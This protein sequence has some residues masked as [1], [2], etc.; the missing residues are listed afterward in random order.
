ML[1]AAIYFAGPRT[2]PSI[3][4]PPAASRNNDAASWPM[5]ALARSYQSAGR[6]REAAE[7]YAKLAALAPN[8][9]QLLADYAFVLGIANGRNLN[10]RPMAL[11]QAALKIDPRHQRSLALAGTAAFSDRDYP[12]AIG[13]WER[14]R[15]TLPPESDGA[16]NIAARIAHARAAWDAWTLGKYKP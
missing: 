10:G 16:R 13:Y 11:L 2:L 6:F 1:A 9:A 3:K 7:A 4:T 15:N 12:A 5:L 8:D 14:L